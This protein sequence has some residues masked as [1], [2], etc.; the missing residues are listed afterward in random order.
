M[1][2][3]TLRV[4]VES[5]VVSAM[6]DRKENRNSINRLLINELTQLLDVIERQSEIKILVI[7]GGNGV[8]CTGMDFD[9]AV[10]TS[11]PSKEN[12][13]EY[14]TLLKRFT[15]TSKV[16]VAKIEGQVLA[17]GV[18][19]AAACDLVL[20]TPESQLCLSELLW[21]LVPAMV[22]PFLIRRIGPQAAYRMAL[23][24]ETLSAEEAG[25]L[26]LVDIVDLDLNA[27]LKR[28]SRR[29]LR[30]D[31]G[32]VENL[33]LFVREMWIISEPM[34][35]LAVSESFRIGSSPLVRQNLERFIR[36]KQFPWE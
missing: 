34:E 8:F 1:E 4:N 5:G 36:H 10:A 24:T 22:M 14:M 13:S 7:S 12:F 35:E 33:K 28:I 11:S 29:L 32:A 9:E 25:R 21:G 20:A 23:T 6:I 15:T 3:K 17:G 30:L 2:F 18:G 27:A 26:G 16:L 19:V 31:S